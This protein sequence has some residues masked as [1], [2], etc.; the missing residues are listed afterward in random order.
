MN[1]VD[2]QELADEH[3]KDAEVLLNAG[4]FAGAYYIAGYAVECA[5]KAVIAAKTQGGDFPRRDAAKLYVHDLIDLLVYAQ[6]GRK[7]GDRGILDISLAGVTTAIQDSWN[8]VD[9]WSEQVRYDR[10]IDEPKARQFI[11]AVADPMKGILS[12]IKTLW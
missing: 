6:L 12:W 10:D 5:L 2:F 11:E 4:R 9:D 1:R 3:V 8:L 7:S